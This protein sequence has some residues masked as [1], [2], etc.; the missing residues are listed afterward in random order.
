MA[1]WLQICT[2]MKSTKY[3]RN[4]LRRSSAL[5]LGMVVLMSSSIT[6]SIA[7]QKTVSQTPESVKYKQAIQAFE[8]R[9][10]D[11]VKLRESLEDKAPKL[12]KDATPEEIKAHQAAF[13]EMVRAARTGAKRGDVFT[14]DISEYIRRLIRKE[15]KGRER[16]EL[17]E[18][19]MEAET[20]GVPLRVNY[21][22][23][24]SKELTQIPPT[25]L[26]ALPQLP[27][28][29]RYRFVG[30][31]MLLMDRENF[32]IIDYMTDALP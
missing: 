29:M 15:F 27:K 13:T 18:T 28:Q 6:P 17:R 23:P 30:R 7:Q 25:L 5:L 11:Y 32:L 20:K 22:Y 16:A 31:H 8:K 24:E 3:S 26:L 21:P 14:P 4:T 1:F 12:S 10:K 19:I 9:V 2:L